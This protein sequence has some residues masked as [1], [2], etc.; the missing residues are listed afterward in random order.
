[1]IALGYTLVYGVLLLINFAH[2]DVVMI[3]AFLTLG[4]LQVVRAPFP[5]VALV[6]LG[7]AQP[8]LALFGLV[9]LSGAIWTWLVKG[10]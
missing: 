4:L 6:V 5:L 7:L 9:D 2:G 8:M 10:K 1:M 3:G